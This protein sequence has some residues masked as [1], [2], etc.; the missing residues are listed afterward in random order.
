MPYSFS[1]Q[2]AMDQG[3]FLSAQ[4]SSV[5]ASRSQSMDLVIKTREGDTVTLSS[6]SYSGV[7]AYAYDRT[8][9][10]VT[11]NRAET[12]STQY[13]TMTLV[14]GEEFSFSVEGD[15]S[16]GELADI[17]SIIGTLDE[18]VG[19]M[20]S[21]DMDNALGLAMSMGGYDTVSGFEA[22]LATSQSYRV[23]TSAVARGNGRLAGQENGQGLLANAMASMESLMD[24]V[25]QVL[26]EQ[27]PL[28][29]GK[30]Q[31]PI[32][33]LL[34]YYQQAMDA[35]REQDP[36]PAVGGTTRGIAGLM[37]T[38]QEKINTLLNGIISDF[39]A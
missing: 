4:E 27:D 6:S 14:S 16:D 33:Q 21:G 19:Q 23:E 2:E 37:E 25:T 9:K 30:A 1:S 5:S 31:S 24:S 32:N 15:L 36:E 28:V 22:D 13:R 18:I 20:A 8:G 11:G 29:L 26:E 10:I 17:Q 3:R 7:D 12:S 38:L 34:D 39:Q 35:T